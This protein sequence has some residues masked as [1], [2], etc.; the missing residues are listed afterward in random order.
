MLDRDLAKLYGVPTK[1]LNEQ[2]KRNRR[3]FPDDFMF[4]LNKQE[5]NDLK[6]HFATSRWGGTRKL[7]H[8]FTEQGVAMLS[9]VLHSERAIQVNIV[10][11]RTFVKLRRIL[12]TH[13]ELAQKLKELE[14]KIAKHDEDI[15]AVFYA[16]KQLMTPSEK[17]KRKIGFHKE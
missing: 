9:S 14:R 3:R 12:S 13:K 8:A 6:S 16:I 11:V 10:I 7:P 15:Q 2:V 5:Y 4:Q 1:R 17:P